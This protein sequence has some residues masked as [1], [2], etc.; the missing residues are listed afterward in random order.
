MYKIETH[1]HFTTLFIMITWRNT[2]YL[3]SSSPESPSWQ[4]ARPSKMTQHDK[5]KELTDSVYIREGR[6]NPKPVSS[7]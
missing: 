2:Y 4:I 5:Q 1:K 3:F 6:L 7:P